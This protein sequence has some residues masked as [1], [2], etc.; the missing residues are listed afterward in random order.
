MLATTLAQQVEQLRDRGDFKSLQV[1]APRTEAPP[2]AAEDETDAADEAVA[3]PSRTDAAGQLAKQLSVSEE[4]RPLFLRI[5]LAGIP[6]PGVGDDV[7]GEQGDVLG[8]PE[9]SWEDARVAVL[10]KPQE[11]SRRQLEAAGWTCFGAAMT[12]NEFARLGELV[13][14]GG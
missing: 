10:L 3:A 14:R 13:Q 6:T 9:L 12:D 8:S 2:A 11:P 7:E 4:V 5:V 1:L